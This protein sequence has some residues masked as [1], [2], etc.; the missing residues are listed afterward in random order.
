MLL[1]N[2]P[3]PLATWADRQ[4]AASLCHR[5]PVGR[6]ERCPHT[7]HGVLCLAFSHEGCYKSMAG[8][9][10]EEQKPG[11]LAGSGML[12]LFA[13]GPVAG[14]KVGESVHMWLPLTRPQWV[15]GPCC[16]PC[17]WML[18]SITGCCHLGMQVRDRPGTGRERGAS[19]LPQM[20]H[21]WNKAEQPTCLRLKMR[22]HCT[23]DTS[24]HQPGYQKFVILGVYQFLQPQ[25]DTPHQPT[26]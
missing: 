20:T 19:G 1:E 10:P 13:S 4:P 3:F 2:H 17:Q 8:W 11:R 16:A 18:P 6:S 7:R 23:I 5:A 14:K 22:S 21:C 24:F 9:E 25:T 15:D 26:V 12:S